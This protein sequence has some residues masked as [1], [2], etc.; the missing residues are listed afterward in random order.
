MKL[1]SSDV[2]KLYFGSTEI[3]KAYLGSNVIWAPSTSTW[4]SRQTVWYDANLDTGVSTWTDQSGNGNNGTLTVVGSGGY[5]SIAHVPGATPYWAFDTTNGYIEQSYI[6]SGYRPGS[7]PL[8]TTW[9][10]WSVWQLSTDLGKSAQ[11]IRGVDS[12]TDTWQLTYNA[13]LTKFRAQMRNPSLG[14]KD[15]AGTTTPNLT[16]WYF[17]AAVFDGSEYQVWTNNVKEA[18]RTDVVPV[19]ITDD[20]SI[21]VDHTSNNTLNRFNMGAVGFSIGDYMT[22]ADINDMYTHYNAIYSF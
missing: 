7:L 14:T 13:N 11:A 3:S 6:N 19:D 9:T 2:S 1:G 10:M 12:G 15:L 20:I 17:V 8:T 16:D 5:S 4:Q 22:A 18:T 21:G